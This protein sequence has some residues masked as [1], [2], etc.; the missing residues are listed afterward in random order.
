MTSALT[1]S[2]GVVRAAALRGLTTL[3]VEHWLTPNRIQ[4]ALRDRQ[5]SVRLAAVQVLQRYPEGMT[6]GP[7][8]VLPL[9]ADPAPRVVHAVR[10]L[11][12]A[13]L[14]HQQEPL[15]QAVFD[16]NTPFVQ[17]AQL[18]SILTPL[19]DDAFNERLQ[20]SCQ[21]ALGR[22][23]YASSLGPRIQGEVNGALGE[24]L[25]RH[26]NQLMADALRFAV[27]AVVTLAQQDDELARRISRG[28]LSTH[29]REQ[30]LAMEALSRLPQRVLAGWVV[31]IAEAMSLPVSRRDE[32]YRELTG[33][34]LPQRVGLAQQLDL[35]G[36]TY[37]RAAAWLLQ[38]DEVPTDS[39]IR[40]LWATT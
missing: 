13:Q 18:L 11:L 29:A 4:Q 2:A 26:I 3:P 1:D 38:S 34:P 14:P 19:R 32:L 12:E 23:L 36:G 31:R 35:L 37:L 6:D 27:L 24:F 15:L 5:S 40:R 20:Q 30:G 28:L 17:R 39:E 16:L 8:L 21:Q 7:A 25:Q 33:K 10:N 9:L 22:V